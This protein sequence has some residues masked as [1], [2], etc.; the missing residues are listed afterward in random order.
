[1]REALI[2]SDARRHLLRVSL[3]QTA[4]CAL[5]LWAAAAQERELHVGGEHLGERTQL[6]VHAL[7]LREARD[8]G[9]EGDVRV[10]GQTH[11]LLQLKFVERLAREI[12]GR[13]TM[14]EMRVVRGVPLV[15]ID[16][17]EDAVQRVLPVAQ[18]RVHA[19]AVFLGG[20]FAGVAWADRGE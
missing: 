6:D 14:L 10:D 18:Q 4:I 12:A 13:V 20:D 11:F 8:A 16:A 17:V 5:E 19:A 7:L 15:V 9:E 1:M 2:E 3:G